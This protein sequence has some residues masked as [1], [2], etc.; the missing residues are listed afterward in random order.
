MVSDTHTIDIGGRLCQLH[1]KR[2]QSKR[3][4]AKPSG[5]STNA[6][7]MIER[8]STSPSVSTLY[9]LA[10]ALDVP[11]TAIFR[12]EP[13]RRDIV[14]CTA[15]DRTRISIPEGIWEGLGGESLTGENDDHMRQQNSFVFR[16]RRLACYNSRSTGVIALCPGIHFAPQK[17]AQRI[18]AQS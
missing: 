13:T 12:A 6:L 8:G 4:L 16:N 2:G 11:V 10:D 9:K 17:I 18:V 7:S 5:L 3:A 1:L 15:A 14:Y